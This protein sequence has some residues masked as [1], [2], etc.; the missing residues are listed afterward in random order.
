MKKQIT[1]LLISTM[2]FSSIPVSAFAATENRISKEVILVPNGYEF[3]TSTAPD[4]VIAASED[5]TENFKF[6][7]TLENAVWK[8]EGQTYPE[9]ITCEKFTSTTRVFSVDVS[10][11]DAVNKDIRIPL[12][13]ELDGN[14]EVYAVVDGL[15]ST[16]SNGKYCF[17]KGISGNIEVTASQYSKIGFEQ[18]IK[19]VIIEDNTS[20]A[21]K[22]GD[23]IELEL[24]NGFVFANNI[25]VSG[26]GKYSGV[27]N[28]EK[29]STNKSKASINIVSS[30]KGGIGKIV[31]NDLLIQS[32]QTSKQGP[33]DLYVKVGNDKVKVNLGFYST[34]PNTNRAITDVTV[35]TNIDKP[36]IKGYA[37]P[38]RK[39]V[40]IIDDVNAGTT[41]VADDGSFTINYSQTGR[42]G[43]E[44]GEHEL[45]VGYY[46]DSTSNRSGEVKQTFTTTYKPAVNTVSLSIG[47]YGYTVSTELNNKV[48]EKG[49]ALDAPAFIDENGRTMLPLRAIANAAGVSDQ[50]I[51]WDAATQTVTIS[52]DSTRIKL[53]VGESE[54]NVNGKVSPMDTKAVIVSDRVFVPLRAILNALGVSDENITWNQD[55][56]KV[57]FKY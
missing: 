35:E 5:H 28:F 31:I 36:L 43:L 39:V 33:V 18:K 34:S 17:A 16:V 12:L 23:K 7:V 44:E 4:L 32:T 38:G 42:I 57:V 27:V 37:E 29:D 8:D 30:T 47:A 20:V 50:N 55:A 2:L 52:K 9:G 19:E 54:I 46:L 41:V 40:A 3:T 15:D 48:T 26:S 45:I 25:A 14:G 24:S 6:T 53:K 56:K 49:Y 22:Y 21:Y 1:A 10:K 13:C 11:F 51:I